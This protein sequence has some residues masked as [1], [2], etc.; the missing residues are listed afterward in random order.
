SARPTLFPY[1]TL[2]RSRQIDQRQQAMAL[3]EQPV[4]KAFDQ[5]QGNQQYGRIESPFADAFRQPALAA[6]KGFQCRQVGAAALGRSGDPAPAHRPLRPLDYQP[7]QHGQQ[8]RAD[9]Q[10][11][12]QPVHLVQPV[13]PS[14]QP[15]WPQGQQHGQ[16]HAADGQNTR[17]LSQQ[18]T[19]RKDPADMERLWLRQ[20]P[21]ER[22]NGQNRPEYPGDATHDLPPAEDSDSPLGAGT[23]V[24][25][26]IQIKW[27]VAGSGKTGRAGRLH[28]SLR[29]VQPSGVYSMAA[30]R[31]VL[32]VSSPC[33]PI[34]TKASPA[35]SYSGQS[36]SSR[37]GSPV[38]AKLVPICIMTSAMAS[39]SLPHSM[40]RKMSSVSPW[41]PLTPLPL[42]SPI[43]GR[44][45]S[46]VS[47]RPSWKFCTMPSG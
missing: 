1:T 35:R 37:A 2:F 23:G 22:R 42:R 33:G 26:M 41:E 44:R 19:C 11:F 14:L 29:G 6:Q 16:A 5:C 28:T 8:Q 7:V 4:G 20:Q 21:Q 9:A 30:S 38:L 31:P 17:E 40:D 36:N 15:A 46:G 27:R 32:T 43:T 47:T 10:P 25:A 12:V 18:A 13:Q 39:S 24:Q 45:P 3:V 34:S